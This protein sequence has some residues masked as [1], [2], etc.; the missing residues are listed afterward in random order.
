MA[1]MTLPDAD[2]WVPQLAAA[3]QVAPEPPRPLGVGLWRVRAGGRELVA[4]TGRGVVDEAAG[5]SALAE[6]AGAPPVPE[7]VLATDDLLVTTWVDQGRRTAAHEVGLGGRL[8][9]L[10]AGRWSTWGGGSHWVGGCPVD[11]EPADDAAAYFGRRLVD[12]A[13]RCGL[14]G[15]ATT[16]AGR[17]ERLLPPDGPALV[18]GDLWWGNVLWGANGQPWLIDPSVHGGYPEEDLAMLGLFGAVPPPTVEAYLEVRP[19]AAGW[20]ERV[21]LFQLLPLLV[22]AVLFGGGYR[23]QADGIIGRLI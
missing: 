23:S 16:L 14:E 6:V 11:P 3:L 20:E 9:A 13:S 10:H 2:A 7:V 12:L 15:P 22:H 5:L 4:K 17:L 21:E 1:G 19:L 18:H 8:A